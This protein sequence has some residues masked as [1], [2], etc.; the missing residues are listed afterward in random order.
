MYFVF[1][2]IVKRFRA[3]SCAA[4]TGKFE[5]SA[6]VAVRSATRRS[7]I[8]QISYLSGGMWLEAR[9]ATAVKIRYTATLGLALG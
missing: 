7:G 2:F 1:A 5:I 6:N 8:H 9:A 4:S 3:F